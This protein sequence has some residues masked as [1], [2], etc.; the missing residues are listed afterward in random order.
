LRPAGLRAVHAV[1]AAAGRLSGLRTCAVLQHAVLCYVL[2]ACCTRAAC[3][4]AG[5]LVSALDL[6]VVLADPVAELLKQDLSR[7][8]TGCAA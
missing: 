5:S 2:A 4:G 3:L 8:R 1:R 6:E 7:V